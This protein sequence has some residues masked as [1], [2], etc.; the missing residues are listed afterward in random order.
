LL[1]FEISGASGLAFLLSGTPL[2][3]RS[4]VCFFGLTLRFLLGPEPL[5]FGSA[6]RLLRGY[7]RFVFALP[8]GLFS[9]ELWCPLGLAR[10]IFGSAA[11]I[12]Y[13]A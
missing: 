10:L 12:V 8:L 5:V 3:F 7:K 6:A 13:F 2:S 11:G 4:L 1:S 9:L